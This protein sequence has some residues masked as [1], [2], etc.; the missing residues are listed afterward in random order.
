MP[1]LLLAFSLVL[2]L[3]CSPVKVEQIQ[4]VPVSDPLAMP[5]ATL[6]RYIRGEALGSEVDAYGELVEKLRQA[7]PEK[8]QILQT[9]FERIQAATS[10]Q[11]PVIARELLEELNR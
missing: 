1:Q 2:V 10:N 9:G 4:T 5:R 6:Q 3:A 7:N 11:R 8:A